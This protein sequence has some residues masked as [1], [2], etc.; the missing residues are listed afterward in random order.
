MIHTHTSIHIHTPTYI[1]TYIRMMHMIRIIIVMHCETQRENIPTHIH[2]HAHTY[3]HKPTYTH[4]YTHALTEAYGHTRSLE[5]H[6][7]KARGRILHREQTVK[8]KQ[9]RDV[10]RKPEIRFL[11]LKPKSGFRFWNPNFEFIFYI[12]LPMEN[13]IKMRVNF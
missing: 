1:H 4:I 9:T 2:L 10:N 7:C 3:L 6:E 5:A 13:C 12:F 11:V 8:S